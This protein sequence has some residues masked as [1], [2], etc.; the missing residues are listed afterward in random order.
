MGQE[1]NQLIVSLDV[2]H[3]PIHAPNPAV[4][5]MMLGKVKKLVDSSYSKQTTSGR[6][7]D[8]VNSNMTGKTPSAEV[9]AKH[10]GMS[11]STLKRALKEEGE[12]FQKLLDKQR[13]QHAKAMLQERKLSVCEI[14]FLLGYS[15]A[16]SFTR[17][18]KV[19]AGERPNEYRKRFNTN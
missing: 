6:V 7:V 8:F 17:S 12:A 5:K 19:W 3:L 14:S 2:L 16:S 4:Q 9:T 1:E 13:F 15:N 10:L 11:L 18:F